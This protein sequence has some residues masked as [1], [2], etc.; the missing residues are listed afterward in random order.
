MQGSKLKVVYQNVIFGL[1]LEGDFLISFSLSF[2]LS[3]VTLSLLFLSFFF[4]SLLHLH[5]F[6]RYS[7]S[8]FLSLFSLF[9]FFSLSSNNFLCV[10][11][12]FLSHSFS[13]LICQFS[14]NILTSFSFYCFVNIFKYLYSRL[15]PFSIPRANPISPKGS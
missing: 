9:N 15:L 6:F 5:F 10:L 4:L 8:F 2:F 1:S 14:L 11:F 12:V 7:F 3:F 13:P